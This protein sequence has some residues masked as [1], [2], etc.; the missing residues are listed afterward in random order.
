[1]SSATT[2]A[3]TAPAGHWSTSSIWPRATE[4]VR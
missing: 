4:A 2:C 3:V 1:M